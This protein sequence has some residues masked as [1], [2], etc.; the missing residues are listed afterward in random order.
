MNYFLIQVSALIWKRLH[1]FSLKNFS[2]IHVLNMSSIFQTHFCY[3][4][5][6]VCIYF[7]LVHNEP[8]QYRFKNLYELNSRRKSEYT[9]VTHFEEDVHNAQWL[10]FISY[11]CKQIDVL[12]ILWPSNEPLILQ[13]LYND[14]IVLH[15]ASNSPVHHIFCCSYFAKAYLKLYEEVFFSNIGPF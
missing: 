11:E 10:L 2:S 1:V 15:D 6:F 7:Y 12:F 3:C 14:G 8:F 13:Q 9:N 5:K 4:L